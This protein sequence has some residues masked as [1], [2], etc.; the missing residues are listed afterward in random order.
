[1]SVE[2]I[3]DSVVI[4]PP[5]TPREA[6]A[7]TP[8]LASVPA[9]TLDSLAGQSVLHRMPTGSTLFEQAETPVFALL[10]VDGSVELLAVGESEESLVEI[11][12]APDLLLPAAVLNRQPYLLRARVLGGAGLVMIQADAFRHA[13]TSDHALSLAVLACQAAQFCNS[14]PPN[15][16]SAATCCAW[17][18]MPRPVSRRG[19]LW[20]SA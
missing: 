13:V 19:F 11:V 14:V 4:A 16:A 2:V 20:R 9:P 15:S 8:W 3:P 1:M 7:A 18:R 6:L 17:R 12:Q 5:A 10:L